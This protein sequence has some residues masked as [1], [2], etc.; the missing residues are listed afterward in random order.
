[1]NIL[2][3]AVSSADMDAVIISCG[4]E[5]VT[6]Q[7]VDTNSAWLSAQLTPLGVKVVEHVTVGDDVTHLASAIRRALDGASLVILTGGLGPT[8][9]DVAREAIAAALEKPLEENSEALAQVRAFFDRWQ[10]PMPESNRRQAMIPRGCEVIPNPRGTAPGIRYSRDDRHLYAFPGIP[11]EMQAMFNAAVLPRLHAVTGG[12][13]TESARLL[14]FGISEAKL[15]EL[16]ADLMQRGRNPSVGTT[17][18]QAVLSVRVLAEGGS[19]DEA[20][21]LLQ[22]DVVEIDRRL[23]TII[24]GQ[25]DDTLECVV[26]RLLVEHGKTIATAESCTG[27]LLAKRLTDIPG[28]SA[29]FLRGYVTYADAAKVDL[30]A[31]PADLVSKHGAVS[32]HVAGAMARGCRRA[33]GSDY[34]ISI[35]GIA[36]PTGGSPPEKPIGLV[37]IGLAHS[38]GVETLRVLCGD[39]LTR[40]EIRDRSCKTALNL[41]RLRLLG[42]GSAEGR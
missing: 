16:L 11:T 28:S 41:L 26:A 7:C 35:T 13:T 5:L 23:G 22:A 33:A 29:Y 21:R 37:Y 18:S 6:G 20:R 25:D 14:C 17:A 32:E 15:G 12:A 1:V 24:F 9:D 39:H 27:G 38:T 2:G 36:G 19:A 8:L 42:V 3:A 34:A 40:D 4:T 30:L 10:R 31:V